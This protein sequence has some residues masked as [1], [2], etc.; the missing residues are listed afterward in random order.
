[1]VGQSGMAA[2]IDDKRA[3]YVSDASPS[4]EPRY[5]A[6]FYFD[7]NAITLSTTPLTIFYG[8]TGSSTQVLKIDVRYNGGT[9]QVRAGLRNDTNTW[10]YTGWTNFSDS[11]HFLEMDWLSATAA[12]TNNGV[13]TFWVDGVQTAVL[14]GID[15][16][17]RHIDMIR[18]GV[19]AGLA[20]TTRGTVFFDA[21]ESHRST[22]I[23]P[24]AP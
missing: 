16:D 13:L 24:A 4:S 14:N 3:I 5:R 2:V 18:L 17:K 7:P 11:S 23:G 21:F 19:L 12:G 9:Y 8:F 22:Y 20:N 10:Y 1:M 6:R 15:N